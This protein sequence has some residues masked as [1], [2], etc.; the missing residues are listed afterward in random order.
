MVLIIVKIWA[1]MTYVVNRNFGHIVWH[2][3]MVPVRETRKNKETEEYSNIC[4]NKIWHQDFYKVSGV[5]LKVKIVTVTRS[6]YP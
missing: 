2:E 5:V 6:S 3:Q 4:E 1:A